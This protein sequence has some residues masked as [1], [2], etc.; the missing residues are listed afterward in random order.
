MEL[1]PDTS[2]DVP[3]MSAKQWL[4]G[5][6]TPVKRICV[7]QYNSLLCGR[8]I[9]FDSTHYILSTYSLKK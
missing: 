1:Y 7:S 2:G 8:P 6:N 9:M 4:E 5:A 3:A